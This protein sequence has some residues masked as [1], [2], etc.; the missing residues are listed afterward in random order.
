M[1]RVGRPLPTPALARRTLTYRWVCLELPFVS[2][3]LAFFTRLAPVVVIPDRREA[4]VL[5]TAGLGLLTSLYLWPFALM[6]PVAGVVTDAFGPRRTVNAFLVVAG[7]GQVLFAS[8][9]TFSSSMSSSA[10]APR[11]VGYP[12]W[13]TSLTCRRRRRRLAGRCHW[14]SVCSWSFASR[15]RGCSAAMPSCSSAR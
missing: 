2:G 12:R 13:P 3:L 7:V 6:Q 4:F 8:T 15:T 11:S 14:V 5:G 9:P 1:T 10:T